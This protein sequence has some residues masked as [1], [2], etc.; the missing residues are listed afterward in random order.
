[1]RANAGKPSFM[2]ADM[3]KDLGFAGSSSSR[4]PRTSTMP[5]SA[6]A[7]SGTVCK[8]RC[9]FPWAEG[10]TPVLPGDVWDPGR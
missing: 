4:V 6:L 9:S 7:R 2:V 3:R 1:M 10:D 8:R 5:S